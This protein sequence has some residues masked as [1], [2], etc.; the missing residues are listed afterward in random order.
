MAAPLLSKKSVCIVTGATRGFGKSIA[1]TFSKKLPPGSLF[2]LLSRNSDLLNEVANLVQQRAD[3][4]AVAAVFD[5]SS[6]N[7]DHFNN[8][9]TDCM[10]NSEVSPTDFEQSLLINNAG[11]LE[12][13]EFLRDLDNIADISNFFQTNLVGC[14]ALTAKF[15]QLFK[16]SVINSRVIINISSL[17]AISPMKSWALYCMAKAA[18]DMML[19]VLASEEENVRTLNYAPGPLPTDMLNTASE[20]TKDPDLKKWFEEQ[21]A[22]KTLVDCDDSARKLI[23]VLDKNTFENGAH[24]DYYD[25]L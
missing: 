23:A 22:Q 3:I 11:S 4:R 25:E 7:Q 2:I 20:N 12:P 6:N 9:I 18:R 8:I 15:L 17:G 10:S 14:V 21:L 1:L 19:K 24:F 5:Q 16:P 13:L